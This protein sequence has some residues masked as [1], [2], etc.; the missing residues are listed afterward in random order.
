MHIGIAADHGG[1]EL[2]VQL[3]AALKPPVMGWR[4]SAPMSWL[5]EMTTRIVWCPWIGWWR[6]VSSPGDW[7]T[8]AAC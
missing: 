2:K 7:P 1:L 8:A 3:T 4:T 5:Q 6:G